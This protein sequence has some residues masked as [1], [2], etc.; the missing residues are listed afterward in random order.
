M[1]HV[2]VGGFQHETNTF[3]PTPTRWNHFAQADSWPAV[4]CKK[5][6]T[7]TLDKQNIPLAGFL[8]AA[9]TLPFQCH[10][11][12]WCSAPPSGPVTDDCFTQITQLFLQQLSELPQKPNALFLDLHG[13][14][15]CQSQ[16]DA[17]G[18]FLQHLRQAVGED[19][20]IVATL[21]LHANVTPLMFELTDLLISY[22]TYPHTDM[23]LTGQRAAQRLH[24][25]WRQGEKPKKYVH[26]FDF[27]IP[28][29]A[30]ASVIEPNQSIYQKLDE[31]EHDT[32]VTLSFNNGFPLADTY[33]TGPTL[34]SYA[35]TDHAAQQALQTLQAAITAVK[36]HYQTDTI[37]T[38]TVP[39]IIRNTPQTPG[40][41]LIFAD[42][43]DNPGCGGAGNTIDILRACLHANS[44]SVLFAQ[45]FSPTLAALFFS[46]A[47]GETLE[48]DLAP[49]GNPPL[50]VAATLLCKS[51]QPFIA[52]GPF[53][54]GCRINLGK[55]VRVK[56]QAIELIIASRNVQAA[57]QAILTHIGA[58]PERYRALVLKSSVHFR[59]DFQSLAA[60]I[61]IALSPGLN[62][63]RLQDLHYQ[64]LRPDITRL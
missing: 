14:M 47:V 8:Q 29:T 39:E 15:V 37:T 7:D 60:R 42:T 12:T 9:S 33:H 13:A 21:D 53:Y 2:A 45:L 44:D 48:C 36:P 6:I 30:Q 57:D 3:S 41:P 52:T 32:P 1:I 62:T 43:Q 34:L 22:R 20:W 24:Q 59:A 58:T 56:I 25:Y 54:R 5:E 55:V 4:L 64:Q 49:S 46:A 61:F 40:R 23:H 28:M 35:D 63:G 51:D 16:P 50:P 11:L 31:L 19:C 26:A 17:E 18:C 27:L 10:P 38:Q